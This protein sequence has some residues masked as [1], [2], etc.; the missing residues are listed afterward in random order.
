MLMSSWINILVDNKVGLVGNKP[1]R[2]TNSHHSIL[3]TLLT[4][5]LIIITINIILII[6]TINIIV[7]TIKINIILITI[8]NLILIILIIL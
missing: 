7:I 3:Q 4:I 6:I 2:P 1:Y 8:I 5:T